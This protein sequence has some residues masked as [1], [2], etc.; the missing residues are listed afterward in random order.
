M[1][2]SV[3]NLI[4]IRN[5]ISSNIENVPKSFVNKNQK[6]LKKIDDLICKMI[7]DQEFEIYLNGLLDKYEDVDLKR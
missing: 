5:Y 7:N 1:T 4:T 6:I 2:D 3:V